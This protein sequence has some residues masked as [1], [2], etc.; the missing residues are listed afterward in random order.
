MATKLSIDPKVLNYYVENAQVPL[1]ALQEKIKDI[2]KF[3]TGEKQPTFNQ[4]SDIEKK[5]N[6]PTG[7]LLLPKPIDI[8]NKRLEF[9]TLGSLKIEKI[10]DELRDTITDMEKKQNFLRE[11][12]E[13]ELNFIGS[14]SLNENVEK[15]V[16]IIR[17]ALN[18]PII[19][20]ESSNQDAFKYFRSK[21]NELG[22]YVFLDGI[23]RQNTRR[24]LNTKEFRG[25]ALID[26]KAPIIFIN[27]TDVGA[28]RLFTLLHELVHLFLGSEGISNQV[29]LD[30]YLINPD[31]VFA[32]K[33]TAEILVPEKRFLAEIES[34]FD[35]ANL[36]KQ[37]Q[38]SKYVIIRRILDL[39][40]ITK[41]EYRKYISELNNEFEKNKKSKDEKKESGG[42]YYNA[43]KFKLDRS[44]F[45]IIKNAIYSDKITYTQAFDIVGVSYKVYKKLEAEF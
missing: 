11:E 6:I 20:Q 36:A 35:L 33:V 40:K 29:Y 42:N 8:D 1:Y 27:S 41:D 16:E 19:W 17:R 14:I 4:L 21:I 13:G 18:I 7:L 9:R 31:E 12:V 15:V 23:V 37:F 25:F 24:S 39:K 30:D 22:V 45:Y 32:N 44:F 38:V 34:G 43:V 2:D 3:L 26:K 28:G 5:L 10:S